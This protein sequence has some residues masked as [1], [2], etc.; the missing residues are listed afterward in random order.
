[1]GCPPQVELTRKLIRN[2]FK[3]NQSSNSNNGVKESLNNVVKCWQKNGFMS[4]LCGES[5]DEFNAAMNVKSKPQATI[6]DKPLLQFVMNQLNK[7]IYKK[8]QQGKY[9]DSYT[10]YKPLTNSIFEG[11]IMKK[12]VK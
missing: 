7:P 12:E 10:G 9:K 11:V 5:I 3:N 8:H 2:F 4:V 1:M 6:D